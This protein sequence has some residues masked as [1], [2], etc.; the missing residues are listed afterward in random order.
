MTQQNI[1]PKEILENILLCIE[2]GKTPENDLEV[3]LLS[4]VNK[5]YDHA[6]VNDFKDK[7]WQKLFYKE[8]LEDILKVDWDTYENFYK[9]A[10]LKISYIRNHPLPYISDIVLTD[11]DRLAVV[12]YQTEQI[13]TLCSGDLEKAKE[14][15]Q[16]R[17][18]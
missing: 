7:N 5:S 9:L 16:E 8:N 1:N 6:N 12:K 4:S 15:F 10:L 11:K 13:N 2:T 18:Y 3:Y 14:I 17:L